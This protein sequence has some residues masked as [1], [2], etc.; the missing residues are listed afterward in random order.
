MF[1]TKQ[2]FFPA[3]K[4]LLADTS[5]TGDAPDFYGGQKV[6]QLFADVSDTVSTSFQWP[7]F[8]DQV[9]TDWTETVGKSLAAKSDTVAALGAWQKRIT[10]SAKSQGFTVKGA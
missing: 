10:T 4:S 6:N 9:A 1:A 5:F 3:T 8:L 7:P 2:L